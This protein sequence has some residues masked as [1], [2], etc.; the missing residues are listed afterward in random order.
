MGGA[1]VFV[2]I[3]VTS[4]MIPNTFA[5][6]SIDLLLSKPITR[7][8]LFLTKYAGGCAFVLLN[9]S[10]LLAGLWLISGVRLGVWTN[11]ILWCIPVFL[12]LF[13]IYYAV[14]A[15]SGLVWRN[16]IICVVISISFW[17]LCKFVGAGREI[18]RGTSIVPNQLVEL[19]VTNDDL[20]A[21][22]GAGSIVRWQDDDREWEEIF[23]EIK[24]SPPIGDK[25]IGPLFDAKNNR[26]IGIPVES[27]PFGASSV[28]DYLVVGSPDDDWTRK[29]GATVPRGTSGLFL[30]QAGELIVVGSGGIQRMTGD[31]A[32]AANQ[33]D[34]RLK[35]AGIRLPFSLPKADRSAAKD[36]GPESWPD[37]FTPSF[38]TAHHAATGRFAAFDRGKLVVYRKNTDGDY[39]ELLCDM[40]LDRR[41]GGSIALGRKTA[42][43]V[44][45][46]GRVTLVD[47]D[48]ATVIS[49]FHPFELQPQR[50]ITSNDAHWFAID[51]A[52]KR[53]VLV[54]ADTGAV[55]VNIPA[56]GKITAA[57][58]DADDSLLIIDT[59]QRVM[60]WDPVSGSLATIHRTKLSTPELVYHY[61]FDPVYQIFPKPSRLD[62]LIGYLLLNDEKDQRGSSSGFSFLF[63]I[64][65]QTREQLTKSQIRNIILS[66]LAFVVVLLVGSCVY[67]WRKEF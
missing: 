22:N 45:D 2:A 65:Q 21:M 19:T 4:S 33:E 56:Q 61:G 15:L 25:L 20:I 26:L 17:L 24:R 64:A 27:T 40:E 10:Y 43:V 57:A 52:D 29:R 12:F 28:R 23:E 31:V 7:V 30:E 3:L 14:S 55:E 36:V 42:L 58:F 35:I 32:N 49:E 60:R 67:V 48:Q 6:G 39:R 41:A 11:R 59:K 37:E 62:A 13:S 44:D 63:Q 46:Q 66:N 1:G 47:T 51:F 53:L 16:A 38:S 50:I 54:E 18:L 9:A 34:S 8:G 5:P